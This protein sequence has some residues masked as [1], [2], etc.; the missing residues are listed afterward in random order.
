MA[1]DVARRERQPRLARPDR[2]GDREDAVASEREEVLVGTDRVEAE[3]VSERR[4][5]DPLGGAGGRA[6][7]AALGGGRGQGGAID[8]AR[9]RQRQLVEHHD[10]GGHHRLGQRRRQRGAQHV[11]VGALARDGRHVPDELRIARA[12]G[13]DDRR[14]ARHSRLAQEPGLDFA[15]LDAVAAD[16]HLAVRAPEVLSAPSPRSRTMSPVRYMRVPGTPNGSATKRSPVRSGRP[17]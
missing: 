5:Q 10:R 9:G 3:H 8:L 11:G 17:W 12:V 1:E 2:H 7:G 16:L 13:A 14:G 4:A 15:E 6:R